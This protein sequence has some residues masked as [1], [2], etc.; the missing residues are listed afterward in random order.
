MDLM[1]VI[2]EKERSMRTTVIVTAARGRGKSA[3]L[4]AP[5]LASGRDHR[6]PIL[7]HPTQPTHTHPTPP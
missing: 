2:V 7:T 5:P 4:G 6:P 1:A 3:A